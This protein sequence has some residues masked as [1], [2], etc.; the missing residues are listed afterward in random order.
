MGQRPNSPDR[1]PTPS[2]GST[3]PAGEIGSSVSRIGL[4]RD[5]PECLVNISV[6]DSVPT[7][8]NPI[9]DRMS[10]PINDVNCAKDRDGYLSQASASTDRIDECR[11]SLRF[12]LNLSCRPLPDGKNVEVIADRSQL[13][14]ARLERDFRHRG[15]D[16]PTPGSVDSLAIHVH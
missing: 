7:D 15:L 2:I 5:L 10:R 14:Q 8:L 16:E 13:S 9:Q 1:R 4:S 3:P 11:G 6:E 12:E